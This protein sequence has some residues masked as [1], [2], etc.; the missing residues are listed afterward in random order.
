MMKQ[1]AGE[2]DEGLICFALLSKVVC[3]GCCFAT[4]CAS[5]GVAGWHGAIGHTWPLRAAWAARGLDWLVGVEKAVGEGMAGVE[6]GLWWGVVG[7]P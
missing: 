6:H 5:R 2:L 4:G 1:C 3:M 7:A